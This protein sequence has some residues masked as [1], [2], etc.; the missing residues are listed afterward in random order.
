MSDAPESSRSNF[1]RAI[2]DADLAAGRYPHPV[3]RFPPEPNGFLHIGHAKS[4]CLNFG[5]ARD[6]PGG[7]CHLRMDDTN[8]LVEDEKF[9]RAIAEDIR[10]LG[11]DWGD[12][13]FHASDYFEKMYAYAQHLVRAGKAYVC[14]LSVDE[15]RATRGSLTEPGTASPDRDRPPEESLKLLDGMR[16]GEFPD[17]A[18]TL[19][20]KI[21]MT[22][23][24]M[25]MRDPLLYRIRNAPHPRTGEEWSIYPMYD[26]AHCLSDSIEGITHS[27]CTLEFENNRELY[28]WVLAHAP[29]EHVSHQYEFARLAMTYTVLSKRWL[30]QL[31]EEKRVDGWDDPRMPTVAGMRRGGIPPEA[32]V[33][34]AEAVGVTK[35]NTVIDI[36]RLDYE[37]RDALNTRAPRVMAVLD[38]LEVVIT[39]Y[40]EGE[41]E[42]FDAPY[43]PHD[44]PR[45]GTRPVP[46]GR[47]LFIER[48]DFSEDPPKGYYR[49]APGREVRLRYAYYITCE[50]VV[51]DADGAVVRL[52]CTYDPESRGGASPDGRKVR[53]TLHW[54]SADHAVECTARL[55]DR[56]FAVPFPGTDGEWL[57]DLN[58]DSLVLADGALVEPSVLEDDPATRYQFE[59]QGY[60]WRDPVDGCGERLVFNRII[61][62]RDSWAK[63][64]EEAEAASAPESSEAAAEGGRKSDSRP[65]KRTPA[66]IRA[67]I[68][69]EDPT[70]SARYDRYADALGL[71]EDDAD[72]LTGDR[73]LSDLFEAAI[74]AYD[75]PASVAKWAVNVLIGELGDREAADLPFD[76]AELGHLARLADEDVVSSTAAKE[77]LGVLMTEGGRA[78]AIVDDRGLRKLDD[79]A[80]L[81]RIVRTVI[82]GH[83]QQAAQYRGG[84][85]S[86]IGFFIGQV[87]R[88]SG[89]RADPQTTRALLKAALES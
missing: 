87:M 24:N 78:E 31:V 18:Y 55:Y 63:K 28:D 74:A 5:I 11:F 64:R 44:V 4:I 89:G 84:K 10:W 30:K 19:R 50:R 43:W 68:R 71:G 1:I 81:R 82:E 22:S 3:T 38:P 80:A 86:L 7:V 51:R 6:Y 14:S 59:R 61:P 62:L 32:L 60:F 41:E 21:D 39:N 79:E 47:R 83:P 46:F 34:F 27:I 67:S 12:A 20:A 42:S 53:G 8:P 35:N 77:V 33:N 37:I 73:A 40:P 15:I 16:R 88:E 76:G 66:Q 70:L 13:F 48:S 56:L 45:E 2:I 29:V 54:V 85:A 25:L 26:Y 17:G 72:V 65:S 23:P 58:P 75:D 69:A 36:E 9:A 52:E 57:D 49:L